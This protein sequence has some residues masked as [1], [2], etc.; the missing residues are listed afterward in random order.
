MGRCKAPNPTRLESQPLLIV[1]QVLIQ[2]EDPLTCYSRLTH[3]H[4]HTHYNMHLALN[5][6]Y[7]HIATHGIKSYH[8]SNQF[9]HYIQRQ[10]TCH[11]AVALRIYTCIFNYQSIKT[12]RQACSI[13]QI[14]H[15]NIQSYS[16]FK[17]MH[18]H[19]YMHDLPHLPHSIT[20]PMH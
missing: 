19:I 17:K 6:A 15:Q 20:T 18:V 7:H 2:S 13:T 5:M 8:S 4:T 16:S 9:M 12:F 1:F 11:K 14:W 10:Q 3:T